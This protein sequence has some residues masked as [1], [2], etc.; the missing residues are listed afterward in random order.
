M[1]NVRWKQCCCRKQVSKK[2]IKN[3]PAV[4]RNIYRGARPCVGAALTPRLWIGR[5]KEVRTLC[6]SMDDPGGHRRFAAIE[7]RVCTRPCRTKSKTFCSVYP[8]TAISAL[9]AGK[10]RSHRLNP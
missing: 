1:G 2:Y 3:E 6:G 8:E 7:G 9:N 5:T 4:S 10:I